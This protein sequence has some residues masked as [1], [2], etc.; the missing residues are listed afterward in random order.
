MLILYWRPSLHH[1][2]ICTEP[3]K[4]MYCNI[5]LTH[6]NFMSALASSKCKTTEYTRVC[7]WKFLEKYGVQTT[8]YW[9]TLSHC[10][11]IFWEFMPYPVFSKMA[12]RTSTKISTNIKYIYIYIY[13]LISGAPKNPLRKTK[14]IRKKY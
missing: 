1:E 8:N 12:A 6:R 14:Y 11:P 13:G 2:R 5:K 7:G 4:G 10:I 9:I 3:Q